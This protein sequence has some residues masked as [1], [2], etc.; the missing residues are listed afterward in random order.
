MIKLDQYRDTWMSQ[1]FDDVIGFYPREFYPL[2]NFSS[3]KVEFNGYLYSTAE[4]AFQ[5]NLFID[6]YPKIA[7]EIRNFIRSLNLKNVRE[8]NIGKNQ[9]LLSLKMNRNLKL[10][11]DTKYD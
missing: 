2:D 1:K 8:L 11:N 3:F 7:E 9:Y 5:A 4:E 10:Y 6:E